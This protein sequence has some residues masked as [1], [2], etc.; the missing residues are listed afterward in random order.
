LGKID[1][2][3]ASASNAGSFNLIGGICCAPDLGSDHLGGKGDGAALLAA[4]GADSLSPG[5]T[6]GALESKPGGGTLVF[7]GNLT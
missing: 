5:V 3:E 4:L 2:P 7:G 6:P 1:S